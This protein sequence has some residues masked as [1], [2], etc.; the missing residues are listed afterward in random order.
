MEI[1]AKIIQDG[2]ASIY[3]RDHGLYKLL[4]GSRA[5]SRDDEPLAG[6]VADN[7]AIAGTFAAVALG[8]EGGLA[9]AAIVSAATIVAEV[10][11][12]IFGPIELPEP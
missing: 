6:K 4:R 5:V 9:V 1:G 7:D 11:D 8:P 10:V 12:Y 3:S 2:Q